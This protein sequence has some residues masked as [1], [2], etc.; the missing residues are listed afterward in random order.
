MPDL[1][2]QFGPRH[3]GGWRLTF[4]LS[5]SARLFL[6]AGVGSAVTK[7]FCRQRLPARTEGQFKLPVPVCGFLSIAPFM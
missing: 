6:V 3:N 7:R 2:E 4:V 5:Q 1:L